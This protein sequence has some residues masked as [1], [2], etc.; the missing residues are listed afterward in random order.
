MLDK[1]LI[2]LLKPL[3]T[4]HYFSKL[5]IYASYSLLVFSSV[6]L[7][8]VTLS[9]IIPVT[10]IWTKI[11]AALI[12]SLVLGFLWS[13]YK[14]PSLYDTARL[15]D[16]FGLKERTIT[17]L[18][19]KGNNSK[20]AELQKI[21]ATS[22]LEKEDIKKQIS[23]KPSMKIVI[24]AMIMIFSSFIL[25]FINTPSHE[26]ALLKE[27]N[28]N[29]IKNEVENIKKVEKE[30]KEEKLLTL[31]EKKQIE[32]T[33]KELRKKLD[34]SENMKDIQKEAL[35]VKK[36]LK[37]IEKRLRQ[38]KLEDI[39]K[40]LSDKEF[41]KELAENL[42]NRDGEKTAE[43]IEKMAE[44]LKNM[45]KEQLENLAK[46]LA[47]LAEQLKDNPELA[48]AFKQISNAIAQNIEGN[49]DDA[50]I[51]NSL[52]SLSQSLSGLMSNSQ[53][54]GAISQLN[55]ALDNL[56]SA[57]EQ[58]SQGSNSSSNGQS[59]S[60]GNQGT[61]QGNSGQGG[62][63]NGQGQGSGSGQ[64]AGKGQGS[65]GGG[66][67]EGSSPGSE[68]SS[69]SSSGQ[70]G[71][72]DG[73]KKEVKEYESIFTPKNLGGQ[74]N[75]TQVHGN[76]NDSGDKDVIQVKKFGDMKGE[77]MPYNEVLN[78]YKQNAYK[79]LDNEEI[80]S[81]MKEIIRKYFSDLE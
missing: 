39:A 66:A 25:G 40:K 1:K 44:Q 67:G 20:L 47:A 50:K 33:L 71:K 32:N 18:E 73:S 46:D 16:T 8:I 57:A 15:V 22:S 68:T 12:V 74:G 10:F 35:K 34:K 58:I 42:K 6:L 36:E 61:N 65:G 11:I 41:T 31:E 70:S 7:V 38:E 49:M 79:R 56:T 48:N 69:G 75:Q 60:P 55:E 81:N 3:R 27:K 59:N 54:S 76:M 5:M 37:D 24:I 77:S 14:Y 53:V 4:R 13:I 80:P 23:I 72:K 64:G 43:S 45:D 9:R 26:E 19:L 63:G 28:K 29:I 78:I 17:A 21:D 52:N 30:I 51:S 2:E 62:Q